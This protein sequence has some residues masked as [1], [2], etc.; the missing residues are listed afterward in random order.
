[1]ASI[2]KPSCKAC[3]VAKAVNEKIKVNSKLYAFSAIVMIELLSIKIQE[4]VSTKSYLEFY[5][6]LLTQVV[7]CVIFIAI[8]YHSERLRFCKRQ[9]LIVIFL[10]VYYF[11]NML[12][13]V[14]PICW[15]QY[16]AI[17]NYSILAIVC[18]L[19]IATWR[20]I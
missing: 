9:K 10:A 13:L 12:F 14:F 2:P 1:M 8:N 4:F 16:Y 11:L 19:F 18:I 17:V 15:S 6:P 20:N 5:Y 7:L 3:R